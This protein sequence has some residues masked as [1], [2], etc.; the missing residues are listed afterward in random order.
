MGSNY[1]EVLLVLLGIMFECLVLLGLLHAKCP[2]YNYLHHVEMSKFANRPNFQIYM[3]VSRFL[4]EIGV[5]P[6]MK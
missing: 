6:F 4:H 3:Y 2:P 1:H 5:T